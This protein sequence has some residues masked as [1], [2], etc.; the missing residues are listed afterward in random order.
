MRYDAII[1]GSGFGAAAAAVRLVEAGLSTLMLER[2]RPARRDA[3]DWDQ[4]QILVDKRY[5]SPSPMRVRQ[6]R[7]RRYETEY[8]NEVLG[9]MSVFYGGASLRLRE[10][11][12]SRW[13]IDYADME[14]YYCEAEAALHVHGRQGMAPCEPLRSQPYPHQP[15]ELSVPAQR[16]RDAGEGLGLR[17]FPIPLAINFTD[18][19][20]PLCIRCNTCDGFPCKIEAKNDVT[21]TLLHRAQARGLEIITSAIVVRLDTSSDAVT[22][23]VCIDAESGQ[24]RRF[25]A[26]VF[27]LAAG[28]LSSPGI[29]QRSGIRSTAQR[30]PVGHY[31]MRHCNAVVTGIFPFRTNPEQVFHK[32]LCFTDYYNDGDEAVS[33]VDAGPATGIIQDIYTPSAPVIRHFAPFGARSL[34]GRLA[35]NMQN[36]LCVAEDEPRF[37]NSVGLSGDLD[38]F[39][40]PV[41]TVDHVYTDGDIRRRQRLVKHAR[42]ILKS[43]GAWLTRVYEIETFSHAIGTIRFGESKADS[44][45]DETCR[46]RGLENL[47]V[48]DGSFMPTSGGVNPSLTIAANA[49]RVAD[50]IVDGK[51]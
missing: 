48:T 12:F 18:S 14:P 17:P 51:R 34:A 20:R 9:G 33:A 5:R 26:S 2:G 29:L 41:A 46:F 7:R 21:A 25:E 11:D 1:V 40:I 32:Q 3:L 10:G 39:G 6:S 31:L 37:D 47:F 49:F 35:S 27:G 4:R 24:E 45:L 36:L 8:P 44:A 42:R 30:D 38:H 23:A 50:H 28:A 16:I 15:P 13:P 43:A 19:R 22:T